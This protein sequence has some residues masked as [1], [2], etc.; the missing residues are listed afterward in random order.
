M[1]RWAL[2]VAALWGSWLRGA[3]LPVRT[4]STA[5]GLPAAIVKCVARD[6]HGF[7]WLCTEDGL[8]R[9]EGYG[10]VAFGLKDGL[11]HRAVT[12]FLE[13]RRGRLL[14]GDL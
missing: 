2:V 6:S 8:V 13:T 11:P 4:Y 1:I 14:G 5:D 7:L 3:N 12:A 10:F 9:F